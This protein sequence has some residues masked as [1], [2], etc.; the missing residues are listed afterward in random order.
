VKLF[1]FLQI[2]FER[3]RPKKG[4]VSFFAEFMCVRANDGMSACMCVGVSVC[5]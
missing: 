4:S 2:I 5:V 1:G 3:P